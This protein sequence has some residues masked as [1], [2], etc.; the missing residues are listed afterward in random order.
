MSWC[1]L[2]L[3][4]FARSRQG[5]AIASLLTAA[6]LW[7][8]PHDAAADERATTIVLEAPEEVRALLVGELDTLKLSG[9]PMD[10]AGRLG[11]VRR[12]QSQITELLATEGYFKPTIETRSDASSITFKVEP[13]IR[14][15]IVQVRITFKGDIGELGEDRTTRVADLR[16]AWSLKEGEPFRQSCGA[17]PS[18]PCCS[19]YRGGTIRP[20][21]SPRV[22]RKWTPSKLR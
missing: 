1:I 14:A 6:L 12:V 3:F 16:S 7:P 13:G 19:G 2:S 21:S 11:A 17:K 4:G 20:P 9:T 18:E 10:E 15:H 5:H 22:S 8:T